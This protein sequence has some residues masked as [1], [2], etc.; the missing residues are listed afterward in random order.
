[1]LLSWVEDDLGV[2]SEIDK[3]DLLF[4]HEFGY[5]TER[6]RIP[7]ENS[8]AEL[9]DKITAFI[10]QHALKEQNLTILYYGGHGDNTAVD[11]AGYP[12]WRA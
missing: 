11:A 4:Q 12:E 7:S 6:F 1:M 2:D 5:N 10:K 8:A 9:G 3:L